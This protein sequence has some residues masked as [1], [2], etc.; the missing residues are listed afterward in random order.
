MLKRLSRALAGALVLSAAAS[1]NSGDSPTTPITY[2]GPAN[3]VITDLRAGTGA[4]L[5]AGQNITIKY[6]L[7]LYD[8][9]GT[10]SKGTRV[11]G[12]QFATPF[13]T[14]ALIP[15]FVEGL[16]GMKVGGIRRLVIPPSLAYGTTGSGP[17]PPNAW[18]VFDVELISIQ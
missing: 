10:D 4:T 7:W 1:C 9:T 14:A 15:G 13:T 6:E 8:P 2:V 5:A 18:L 3:L 16:T 17:I 12:G 11:D